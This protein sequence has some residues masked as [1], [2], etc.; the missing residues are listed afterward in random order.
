MVFVCWCSFPNN[1]PRLHL[2]SCFLLAWE[3]WWD[4]V[5]DPSY[6][7]LFMRFHLSPH[8]EQCANPWLSSSLMTSGCVL[9]II[10][11]DTF[12]MPWVLKQPMIQ[13]LVLWLIS[14]EPLDFGLIYQLQHYWKLC[15]HFQP[16]QRLYFEVSLC[17][18]PT[19][20]TNFADFT[21]FS[22]ELYN[23]TGRG[24]IEDLYRHQV[25]HSSVLV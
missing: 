13:L 2:A 10:L 4:V 23:V 3:D 19:K 20:N 21:L 15:S 7:H 14:D 8:S 18:A 5:V 11:I 9:F 24:E 12:V 25:T 17:F 16:L 6:C 1:V 22:T